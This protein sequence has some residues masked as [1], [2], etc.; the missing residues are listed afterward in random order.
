M[1]TMMRVFGEANRMTDEEF[2]EALAKLPAEDSAEHALGAAMRVL[3]AIVE[4]KRG[5]PGRS[6]TVLGFGNDWAEDIAELVRKAYEKLVLSR[7]NPFP[8]TETAK[9]LRTR[10]GFKDLPRTEDMNGYAD[11]FGGSDFDDFPRCSYCG[12]DP[13]SWDLEGN[14][15]YCPKCTK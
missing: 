3:D 7:Q 15:L 6:G 2:K 13:V 10:L 5:N 9:E 12:D 8:K 14:T 11:Q 1:T 4:E